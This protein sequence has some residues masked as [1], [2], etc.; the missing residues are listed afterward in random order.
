MR[1]I[2]F[3]FLLAFSMPSIV[4]QELYKEGYLL[5]S[6][7][8]T[9]HGSIKYLSYNKAARQCIF[10]PKSGQEKNYTPNEIF[11]Y[12]IG[13][14]LLFVSKNITD[15]KVRFMEVV[16]QGSVILYAFRDNNQR[17]YFYLENT[18]TAQFELLQQKTLRKQGK[19][20]TLKPFKEVIKSILPKS[21]LVQD[22][23]EQ[24]TLKHNSL[25][26]FLR[27]YDER[28][29]QFQGR[30]FRG[31][32]I[33]WPPKIA[34]NIGVGQSVLTI[35]NYQNNSINWFYQ[36]GIKLQKEVS[37]GTGRL[38]LGLDLLLRYEDIHSGRFTKEELIFPESIINNGLNI[39]TLASNANISGNITYASAVNLERLNVVAPINIK[40][41]FPS[42]KRVF[43]L[44]LGLT[45]Q[46]VIDKSGT[47]YGN[48]RQNGTILLENL[49]KENS[50]RFRTGINM[51][52]GLYLLG[53]NTWFVDLQHSP[54]W[55]D[56]GN[57]NF[58]YTGIRV[59]TFFG[60]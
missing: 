49:S 20:I 9:L 12:G 47:Y 41:F 27:S 32:K 50:Y 14:E 30:I 10:L 56:Q 17:D 58:S 4:A 28:Y 55:L 16:Y 37:R 7:F 34:P 54:A 53:S 26:N 57:L 1:C 43:A 39:N 23:I 52:I 6:P 35:N 11:G 59:G 42:R 2:G 3:L 22:E 8:D 51:G 29:A 36:A 24:L 19:S 18:K 21:E 45:N 44:N 5:M 13:S 48:V 25:S 38:F 31:H 46:Y 33:R 40:Y 15:Q 60:K